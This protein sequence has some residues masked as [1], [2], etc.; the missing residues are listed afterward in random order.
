MLLHW[1]IYKNASFLL[2]PTEHFISMNLNK[3]KHVWGKFISLSTNKQIIQLSE[4]STQK[5]R[6]MGN[7]LEIGNIS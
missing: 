7:E 5:Y 3:N 4:N 2:E 6:Y 1:I